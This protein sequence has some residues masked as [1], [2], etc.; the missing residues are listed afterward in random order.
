MTD[1]AI[2][3]R[4]DRIETRRA[5]LSPMKAP[6]ISRTRAPTARVTSEAARCRAEDKSGIMVSPADRGAIGAGQGLDGR[7][8][9]IEDGGRIDPQP[10]GA[11]DQGHE[12]QQFALVDVGD[13]LKLRIGDLAEHD[14]AVKRQ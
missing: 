7:P 10:D 13:G 9:V 1:A 8:G 5:L 14:R 4:T 12:Q 6:T 11:D 2:S 3:S